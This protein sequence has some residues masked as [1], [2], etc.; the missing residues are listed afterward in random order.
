[1][2]ED[3]ERDQAVTGGRAGSDYASRKT[4]VTPRQLWANRGRAEAAQ[5][6]QVDTPTPAPEKPRPSSGSR[7]LM[8]I[9][10]ISEL[11]KVA[12]ENQVVEEALAP[13]TEAAEV[14]EVTGAKG[15]ED[16]D[17]LEEA[18]ETGDVAEELTE[19]AD[20]QELLDS[21]L[22]EA[23]DKP[24]PMMVDADRQPGSMQ[25]PFTTHGPVTGEGEDEPGT[26][27]A[28]EERRVSSSFVLGVLIIAVALLVGLV[29]AG[30]RS[31]I[32]ELEQR[33]AELEQAPTPT[34]GP[35]ALNTV[36]R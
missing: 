22:E 11:V 29:L 19:D 12:A 21:I 36:Q 33:V 13:P 2:S 10:D 35:P 25:Y 23:E 4:R 31:R 20:D 16:I 1:M 3:A 30:Q 28:A 17:P 6:P 18:S 34:S 27:A 15:A 7:P 32:G 9:T 5:Q 24:E 8:E 26:A 14:T